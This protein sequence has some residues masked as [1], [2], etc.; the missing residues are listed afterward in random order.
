MFVTNK[1]INLKLILIHLMKEG[2]TI[3]RKMDLFLWP[4]LELGIL[5]EKRFPKVLGNA[6]GQVFKSRWSREIIRLLPEL[7]L[8]ILD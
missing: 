1:S 8:R 5:L 4:C 6:M 3:L 2:F 7:S